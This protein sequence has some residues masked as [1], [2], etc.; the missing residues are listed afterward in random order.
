L[1]KKKEK[2]EKREAKVRASAIFRRCYRPAMMD[3]L[4]PTA[5]ASSIL[6]G[7][8]TSLSWPQVSVMKQMNTV[9]FVF[10][11]SE[12]LQQQQ[13]DK[14]ARRTLNR[15]VLNFSRAM[16]SRWETLADLCDVNCAYPGVWSQEMKVPPLLMA[17]IQKIVMMLSDFASAADVARG[18][19]TYN[20]F[21]SRGGS[22]S[23]RGGSFSSRNSSFG[24]GEL[25][26]A[27]F[28]SLAAPH[29]NP[30]AMFHMGM[31][32]ISHESLRN[33]T[34][35]SAAAVHSKDQFK[36]QRSI[37]SKM[38]IIS[39]LNQVIPHVTYSQKD[40]LR[41]MLLMGDS[42]MDDVME[43]YKEG[44]VKPLTDLLASTRISANV[45]R[46][47]KSNSNTSGLNL[48]ML[49]CLA[50]E[51]V[52][53]GSFDNLSFFSNPN[54]SNR[55][56][57]LDRA[58][59]ISLDRASLF[60]PLDAGALPADLD[61]SRTY[62][63][64]STSSF[65]VSPM[66]GLSTS[67]PRTS[68]EINPLFAASQDVVSN[69]GWTS[70]LYDDAPSVPFVNAEPLQVAEPEAPAE[71]AA[72]KPKQKPQPEAE[73]KTSKKK[74]KD[75]EKEELESKHVKAISINL[76]RKQPR[77]Y[78]PEERRIRILRFLEKR[79]KRNWTKKAQ[80]RSRQQFAKSRVRVKGRFVSKTK[81]SELK[82]AAGI[83]PYPPMP[84]MSPQ[85]VQMFA[86]LLQQQQQQFSS[87]QQQPKLTDPA[88]TAPLTTASAPMP[89]PRPN[90]APG[91]P[92]PEQTGDPGNS[93]GT[94]YDSAFNGHT[95]GPPSHMT[96]ARARGWNQNTGDPMPMDA[97]MV[98]RTAPPGSLK[99][100]HPQHMHVHPTW[101]TQN[102]HLG[103]QNV[104]AGF[105][106]IE[107]Y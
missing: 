30:D 80:Y 77:K 86:Q 7:R 83:P 11:L 46:R 52:A 34:D 58:S 90:A 3:S 26:G 97:R 1:E 78:T 98:H 64:G 88:T 42:R 87:L 36:R 102:E 61:N 43:A 31:A 16:G 20:S 29:L 60:N 18:H 107:N 25:R 38:R 50:D 45:K 68:T 10:M 95:H 67:P 28:D 92:P 40:R 32:N 73:K 89:I 56:I 93:T 27:S 104:Q 76:A 100:V 49:N 14:A 105:S 19:R 2:G 33:P 44:D 9:E 65:D 85:Q 106:M 12:L 35:M 24:R 66:L 17:P 41:D 57:S 13:T 81:A 84:N 8:A 71:S 96:R 4:T 101:N 51:D 53:A 6:S 69:D 70:F 22:F 82:V 59:R 63:L 99:P 62:S 5:I 103:N 75:S 94:H 37:S 91:M 39:N 47:M 48:D 54:N 55:S 74:K 15:Q 23:S 21:S 79:K 72:V